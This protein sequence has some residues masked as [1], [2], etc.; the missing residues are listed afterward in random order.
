MK[1][2]YISSDDIEIEVMIT[3]DND[4]GVYVK[5]SNFADADDAE[6][7]AEFLSETLP[8]LLFKTTKL[9]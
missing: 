4:P 7:Y 2:K 6:E 8:L 5:F 9:Q 3:S 1:E